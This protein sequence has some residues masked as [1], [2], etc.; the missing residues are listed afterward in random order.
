MTR[1]A[2]VRAPHPGALVAL[3]LAGLAAL[4]F[5]ALLEAAQGRAATLALDAYLRRVLVF[6]LTQAA[7]STVLSLVLGAALALALARRR[8]VGRDLVLAALG[9]AAVMPAIVVVFSVVAVWGRSGWIA[10]AMDALGLASRPDPFGWP[11][12][13]LAHVFLNASFAARIFLDALARA[14]AEHWRLAAILGFS[15][16]ATFA[17]LDWPILRSELPGLAGLV[18]LLCFTSFAIVLTLGG[19]PGKATLEVAIFSALRVELDF[20]RAAMLAGL[21]LAICLSLT[22]LLHWAVTKAPVAPTER[23]PAARPDA[24]DPRLRILD[25]MVLAIAGA[26]IAPLLLATLEGVLALPRILDADLADAAA[27]SLVVAL[28]SAGLACA[29]AIALAGAAQAAQARRRTRLA[30]AYD[31]LPALVLAVPPFALT[32]GLFLALRGHVSPAQAGFLLLPLVNAIG[33]LPF[34]YRFLAPALATSA[35]R[36]GRVCALLGL[37][38]WRRLVVVD[39]PMARRP[40]AGAFAV[41]AALSFGDFGIVALFGGGELRTLPYLL[42]ERLGSYRLDEAAAIGLLLVAAAFALSAL[43]TRMAD[44]DRR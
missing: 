37:T 34:A 11:G 10:S 21:Q 39:W 25:G 32:A 36:H 19:G 23:L 27:T 12:I 41:A 15:P 14:P 6:S 2:G 31:V 8:F 38:G 4:A 20:A 24:A 42:Y 17:H 30:A 13:L 18:F 29:M 28:V 3:A 5:G 9:A 26:L 44:A 7:L 16:R 33:A 43:A 40:L 35:E 22:L 1:L